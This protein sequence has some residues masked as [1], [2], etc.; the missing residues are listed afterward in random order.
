MRWSDL[1]LTPSHRML[2]Q[3][4]GLWMVCFAGLA[5]WRW[6]AHGDAQSAAL[7][8]VLGLTLGPLGLLAP[9]VMRPIFVTWLVLAFPI[10]WVVSRVCL[11]VMFGFLVLPAGLIFRLSGR[12]VLQLRRQPSRDSYWATKPAP[13]DP[14][15]YFRQS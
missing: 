14:A 15:S 11:V 2:R 7:L 12:D 9:A 1:P 8:A 13:V 5:S 10:G 3:F 4:A 6:L